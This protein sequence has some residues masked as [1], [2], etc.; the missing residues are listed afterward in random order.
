[1]L[2][3]CLIIRFIQCIHELLWQVKEAEDKREVCEASA[4]KLLLFLY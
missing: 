2:L 1:M 3:I 4:L